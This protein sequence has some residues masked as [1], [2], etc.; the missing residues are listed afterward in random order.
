MSLEETFSCF[1]F[2]YFLVSSS[3]HHQDN[4]LWKG[5]LNNGRVGYFKPN[6][7]VAYLG[8]N[9]PTSS[10]SAMTTSTS[11]S[12]S[13]TSKHQTSNFIRGFLDSKNN[14]SNNN[15]SSVSSPYS[16]Q[17][18]KLCPEMI[19]RPQGDLK[20]TGHVGADGA[21]FGDVSFLGEKYY[22]L[23]KQIVNPYHDSPKQSIDLTESQ[24]K[25]NNKQHG[26]G[27]RKLVMQ[28]EYHEISDE[29][30]NP[31]ESPHFDV[32]T[33]MFIVNCLF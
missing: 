21:F 20:H 5:A 1:N 3:H 4:N 31:L 18:R 7:V 27:Q 19:S 11:S 26:N 28:H 22:Q 24:V 13:S 25:F 29:E 17:R 10:S 32:I 14:N 12:T 15:S 2:I 23:P 30:V 6:H 9:L 33:L 8:Q 16:S